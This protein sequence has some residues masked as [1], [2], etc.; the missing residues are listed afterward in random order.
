MPVIVLRLHIQSVCGEVVLGPQKFDTVSF[1]T[2]Q[3]LIPIIKGV[4]MVGLYAIVGGAAL[5]A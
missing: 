3:K 2:D 4:F 1:G 5:L